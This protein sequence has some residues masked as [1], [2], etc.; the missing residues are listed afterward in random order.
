[1]KKLLSGIIALVTLQFGYAQN[2][3]IGTTTPQDILHLYKDGNIRGLVETST[4]GYCGWRFKNSLHEYF[5]GINTSSNEYV[6]YDNTNDKIRFT[7]TASGNVGIG[8]IN[9]V[10][11]LSVSGKANIDSLGIGIATP[12]AGFDVNGTA[13][14][15]GINTNTIGGPMSA[16]VEFFTG[17]TSTGALNAGQTTADIAF[18][19]GGTGGGYRHFISTRHNNFASS[20]DNSIDFYINNSSTLSGSSAPGTG[21]VL[22]LSVNANGVSIQDTLFVPHIKQEASTLATLANGWVNNGFGVALVSFYKDKEERVYLSGTMRFGNNNGGTVLFIL[23]VGYR[24]AASE[25]FSVHNNTTSTQIRVESNGVVSLW[26]PA[27]NTGLSMSGVS[28][29]AVN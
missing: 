22:S 18:N 7:V 8:T 6:I 24:P 23:P 15:R 28:F 1:M 19:Y 29:R 26:G 25:F 12:S 20:P 3:G 11:K 10:N 5:A 4:T 9:P 17:R 14:L 13:L 16:G 2:V 27:N 21:N